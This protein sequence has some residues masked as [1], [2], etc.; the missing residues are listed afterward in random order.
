MLG[1]YTA[2]P[3]VQLRTP[4]PHAAP[5]TPEG[6]TPAQV[7]QAYGFNNITF[8]GGIKGDGKGQTI[9]IIDAF[10]NPTIAN[11]LKVFDQT[12]GLPDPPSFRIVNDRG[13]AS[14]L[15]LPPADQGWAGEITLDV[16]WAHA[17]APAANILLVES[18]DLLTGVN[19]ARSVP[20]V[21]VISCSFGIGFGGLGGQSLVEFLGERSM[22]SVFSTPSGHQGITFS[23]SAGDSGGP[24][25]WPSI[26]SN[27]LSIGGTKLKLS[28]TNNYGSETVWNERAL[29]L[30]A[31]G[32]GQ[33]GVIYQ[34]ATN[35]GDI[36]DS[37]AQPLVST[38]LE[39]LPSFQKG[40]GLTTRGT[41]DVS[42]NADPLSGVAVYS[43]FAF[44]GWLAGGIGGT[45][46]GAPQWAG[47][48]AIADQG[49]ALLGKGSLANAQAIMYSLP[50]SDFHDITVGNNDYIGMGLGVTGN[51]AKPGYDLASGLGTPIANLVVRDLVASAGTS[52]VAAVGAAGGSPGSGFFRFRIR[53]YALGGDSG[54]FAAAGSV[55]GTVDVGGTSAVDVMVPTAVSASPNLTSVTDVTETV[56]QRID[57]TSPLR[58]AAHH[59]GA[60]AS[61]DPVDTYF[62][63]LDGSQLLKIGM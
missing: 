37:S 56:P 18:A 20:G 17:I 63:D 46:A 61:S 45:S 43:S 58:S 19:Y 33:S 48:L 6:L 36:F 14:L 50:R 51:A 24:A 12:F 30:G 55:V 41:P 34:E 27:V 35:T 2:Y 54:G 13:S 11:D 62:T 7:R 5:L 16:E 25:S 23:V 3:M 21:S 4:V 15:T 42:Y 47:L 29:G 52:F 1:P 59:A 49:R 57:P 22:D 32:G 40:L 60:I 26:S 8:A 38:S 44:G 53:S 39:P 9:A 31:G 10:S 28:I